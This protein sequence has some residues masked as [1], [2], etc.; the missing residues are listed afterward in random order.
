M[1]FRCLDEAHLTV[2]YSLAAHY[3][4][5]NIDI[6][7]IRYSNPGDKVVLEPIPMKHPGAEDCS[8]ERLNLAGT[9]RR[10]SPSAT[11]AGSFFYCPRYIVLL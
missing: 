2:I 9:S 6:L 7:Y 11:F 4:Y 3:K 5:I 10:I 1:A 8:L